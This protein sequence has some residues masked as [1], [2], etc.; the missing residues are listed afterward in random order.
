M[1]VSFLCWGIVSTTIIRRVFSYESQR[2]FRSG[3]LRGAT[4]KLA[5]VVPGL[6]FQHTSRTLPE[7]SADQ[8]E[9]AC[10][11]CVCPLIG[12]VAGELCIPATFLVSARRPALCSG[13]L[14]EAC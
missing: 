2:G 4:V 12:L 5:C 8:R 6:G 14:R 3:A 11:V 1:A 9:A 7:R 13:R 10:V